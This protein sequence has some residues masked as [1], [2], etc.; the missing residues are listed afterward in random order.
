MKYDFSQCMVYLLF[1]DN[2]GGI[3]QEFQK[4]GIQ[5]WVECDRVRYK[6]IENSRVGNLIVWG[7]RFRVEELRDIESVRFWQR[8]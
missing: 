1:R 4:F 3:F 5:I 7:L 8:L 2:F 6:N